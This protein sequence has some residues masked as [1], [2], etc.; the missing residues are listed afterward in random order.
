MNA[1]PKGISKEI[2]EEHEQIRKFVEL[3]SDF[4]K[5]CTKLGFHNRRYITGVGTFKM[6]II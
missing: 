2:Y 3:C 5:E 6:D 1:R 4:R